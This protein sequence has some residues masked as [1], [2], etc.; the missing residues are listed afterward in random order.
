VITKPAFAH[1]LLVLSSGYNEPVTYAIRPAGASGDAT[2]THVAWQARK[3]AP[4]TPSPLIV[5]DELYLVSDK[6]IATCSDLRTGKVHWTQRIDGNYSASPVAAEGRVYFQNEE[7]VGTV[8]RAGK[9]FERLAENDLEEPSLAS[10]AVAEGALYIRTE[11]HL[12]KIGR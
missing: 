5:G 9:Q 4:N 1:G 12:W 7:G 10:Y 8:V 2:A 6:G 3:A 11:K